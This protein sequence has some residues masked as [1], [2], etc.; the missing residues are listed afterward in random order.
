[1]QVGIP[2]V[3]FVNMRFPS[4]AICNL[5]VSWLSP[6]KLRQTTIVGSKKMLIYDDTSPTERVK[7]FDKGV[8]FK[9][10]DTFDIA[11]STAPITPSGTVERTVPRSGTGSSACLAITACGVGPANGGRPH[12]ISYAKAPA[13]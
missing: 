3:A 13:A 5:N 9:D 2:D 8:D 1:M 7:I 10:P 12:S 11:R 4:G 6:S